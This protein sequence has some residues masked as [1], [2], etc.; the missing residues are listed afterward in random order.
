MIFD[1]SQNISLYP[2]T[3]LNPH[4][5]TSCLQFL[6]LLLGMEGVC[7]GGELRG[8]GAHGIKMNLYQWQIWN[9]NGE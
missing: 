3:I 5:F 4:D 1:L 8:R 2:N 6:C 9:N 7:V